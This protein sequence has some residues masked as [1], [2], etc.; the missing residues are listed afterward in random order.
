MALTH[1]WTYQGQG[2][3]LSSMGLWPFTGSWI[4]SRPILSILFH[5]LFFLLIF[6]LNLL[7]L[8][9]Q[10]ASAQSFTIQVNSIGPYKMTSSGDQ[11][12]T[13]RGSNLSQISKVV[14][15]Q[16]FPYLKSTISSEGVITALE[17]KNPYIYAIAD[18]TR[19]LVI[20]IS[21]PNHLA[22][23]DRFQD[24][25]FSKSLQSIELSDNYLLITDLQKGLWVIDIS[26]PGAPKYK[27]LLS[28]SLTYGVFAGDQE[29]V[30]GKGMVRKLYLTNWKSGL[31]IY[32]WSGGN[33]FTPKPSSPI[34]WGELSPFSLDVQIHPVNHE[35][36]VYIANGN[37][38]IIVQESSGKVVNSL[39]AYVLI[40]PTVPA[41]LPNIVDV[42]VKD[43]Y[44]YLIDSLYG[45]Y[46]LD[47]KVPGYPVV[48]CRLPLPDGRKAITIREN[49]AF[50]AAGSSG[51]DLIDISTPSNPVFRHH[52]STQ[53][54]AISVAVENEWGD[55]AYIANG[56]AG[57]A[58]LD[59]Q[60]LSVPASVGHL[61]LKGDIWDLTVAANRVYVSMGKL[62]LK[63]VDVS[64]PCN[65]RLDY[66]IEKA[67]IG[68]GTILI[69]DCCPYQGQGQD[70]L[71]LVNGSNLCIFKSS[72]GQGKPSL[73]K[74]LA[75]NDPIQSIT[76]QDNYLYKVS[77]VQGL[78]IFQI[79]SGLNLSSSPLGGLSLGSMPQH[80]TVNDHVAYVASGTEGLWIVNVENPVSPYKVSQKSFSPSLVLDAGAKDGY[81]YLV[82]GSYGLTV[83][84]VDPA[85][86]TKPVISKAMEFKDEYLEDCFIQGDF[87][88][89]AGNTFGV[90]IMDLATPSSPT[91]LDNVLTSQGANIV[92]A[93]QKYIYAGNRFG[94]LDIYL[95]PRSLPLEYPS[96]Q[97]PGGA[98]TDPNSIRFHIPPGLPHGFYDLI[99]LNAQGEMIRTHQAV[100]IEDSIPLD[101]KAG[102][103]LFGYPGKVPVEYSTSYQ[104]MRSMSDTGRSLQQQSPQKVS[105]WQPMPAG[106]PPILRGDIFTIEERR[107][108]LLYMNYDSLF[109]GLSA[110]YFYPLDT[111]LQQISS[112]L[113]TGSNLVSLPIEG[114]ESL[115]FEVFESLKELSPE[116]SLSGVQRLNSFSGKFESTYGFYNQR[117][118]KN[119]PIRKGEGYLVYK[120]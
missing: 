16:S 89:A 94:M 17:F 116:N 37:S 27:G 13:A 104:L 19:L 3:S 50:V 71:Y 47:I 22:V 112:E 10:P 8:G 9:N 101:L 15:D 4:V 91:I 107:A 60:S 88:Y 52:I 7:C 70:G 58:L 55:Y 63:V 11:I 18:Y 28:D 76:I 99:F 86:S 113:K 78:R 92:S 34:T 56:D 72:N 79:G 1:I 100:Q 95:A 74:T 24:P 103:N 77:L 40:D 61:P 90:W 35:R 20:D 25:Q 80:I 43:T 57:F 108:Y 45:L 32:D 12:V 109:T 105:Y 118:G 30:P 87:L 119:F 14:L 85:H 39:D 46:V 62:G 69:S 44:V 102:L 29:I 98:A 84:N 36:Y 2:T 66:S 120:Y 73:M 53:G 31:K 93:D 54:N 117:C 82:N 111:V 96:S 67:D 51:L 5:V 110:D 41:Y 83:V 114:T 23:K 65:P 42:K 38:V 115:S 106:L 6:F 21:D 49:F 59:I 48:V 64:D 33:Q 75:G 81:A 26:N 97:T 68:G